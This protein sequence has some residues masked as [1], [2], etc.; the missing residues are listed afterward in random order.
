MLLFF[1][2]E[3]TFDVGTEPGPEPIPPANPLPAPG[4]PLAGAT[5]TGAPLDG[6]TLAKVVPGTGLALVL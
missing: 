4:A 6:A 3:P 2:L 5:L 1:F